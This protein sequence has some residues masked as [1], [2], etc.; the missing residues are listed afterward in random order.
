MILLFW[1]ETRKF[2]VNI[3]N[4]QRRFLTKHEFP[5]GWGLYQSVFKD[6]K[7]SIIVITYNYFFVS[8]INH[9]FMRH[10]RARRGALPLRFSWKPQQTCGSRDPVVWRDNDVT[11]AALRSADWVPSIPFCISCLRRCSGKNKYLSAD[12]PTR[13][14]VG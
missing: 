4:I 11:A 6:Q 1:F 7:L 9:P 12:V 8:I 2:N 13:M 10:I 14:P 3:S 5:W